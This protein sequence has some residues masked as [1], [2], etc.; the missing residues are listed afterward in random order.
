MTSPSIAFITGHPSHRKQ[1]DDLSN[2]SQDELT[3]LFL[4]NQRKLDATERE[5]RRRGLLGPH[6]RGGTSYERIK[7]TSEQ[8]AAF[9]LGKTF[10]LGDKA[11]DAA[12]AVKRAL[13]T[14]YKN[15]KLTAKE[16]AAFKYLCDIT[17]QCGCKV[18][19]ICHVALGKHKLERMGR[20]ERVILLELLKTNKSDLVP[21]AVITF[22]Q[23]FGSLHDTTLSR[24]RTW[25]KGEAFTHVSCPL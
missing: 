15:D 17:K 25:D 8:I 3:S 22:V 13:T 10:G 9:G 12:H 6:N 20:V 21:S 14:D 2:L 23:E 24:K 7:F 1:D 16:V 18:A 4:E 19:L 5:L 11:T